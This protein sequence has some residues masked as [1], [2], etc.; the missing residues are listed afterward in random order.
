MDY[1]LPDHVQQL[2][3]PLLAH[4]VVLSPAA[5]IE[6]QAVAAVIEQMVQATPAPR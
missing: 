1:V 3:V 4:R 2:V 6:G 5:E